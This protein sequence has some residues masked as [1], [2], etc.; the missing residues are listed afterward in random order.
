MIKK[1]S[2][3]I[4][5]VCIILVIAAG[6]FFFSSWIMTGKTTESPRYFKVAKGS[7]VRQIANDLSEEGFIRSRF[8]F[9]AAAKLTGLDRKIKAGFYEIRG[10]ET[11][12]D[13]VSGFSKGSYIAIQVTIPEGLTTRRIAGLLSGKLGI[14]ST[15]F[16]EAC[17]D[18]ALLKSFGLKASTFEGYLLPETYEFE[19]GVTARDVFLKLA[20]SAKKLWE[21]PS[22][23]SQLKERNLSVHTVLTMASIVEGEARLDTERPVIAGLYWNRVRIGMHLQADPTIQFLLPGGPRRLLFRDLELDSPYNTYLHAG[24]PPGPIG[25]PG[26]KSI[27]AALFPASH[28]FLYMVAD[29]S[30]GHTFSKTLS[31]H[32]VAVARYNQLMQVRRK[33][34]KMNRNPNAKP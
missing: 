24:L 8:L 18:S 17:R 33:E 28:G 2:L 34:Q 25:N 20:E 11:L 16:M 5:S 3:F 21:S 6:Y 4:L 32:N 26:A 19:Y 15:S 30:G 29:G 23:I 31:E 1:L 13:L 9:T 7:S 14:D 27:E 22:W 10:T 12:E